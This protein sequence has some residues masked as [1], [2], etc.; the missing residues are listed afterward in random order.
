MDQKVLLSW[1]T[2]VENNSGHFNILRSTDGKSFD[3]I[4]KLFAQGISHTITNYSFEDGSTVNGLAY[5]QLEQI[6]RNG[7]RQ[8]SKQIAVDMNFNEIVARYHEGNIQF[9]EVLLPGET[10]SVYTSTGQVIFTQEITTVSS[11]LEVG[12]SQG[13]YHLLIT[14]KGSGQA[15]IKCPVTQ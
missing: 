7:E 5:Y 1:A 11:T 10:V 8:Y 13:V 6:D 15:R 3:V 4:G 14:K 12:L 9:N 2:L